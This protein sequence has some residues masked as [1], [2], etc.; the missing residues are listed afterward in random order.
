MKVVDILKK[1]EYN[2]KYGDSGIGTDKGTEFCK[3][4]GAVAK[5]GSH[6]WTDYRTG[7]VNRCGPGRKSEGMLS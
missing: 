2:P 7:T 6:R 3:R 1:A 4:E 5:D